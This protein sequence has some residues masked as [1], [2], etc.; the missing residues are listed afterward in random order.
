MEKPIRKITIRVAVFFTC[1]PYRGDFHSSL[2]GS[3]S[4]FKPFAS[5]TYKGYRMVL[6]SICE[7]ASIAFY[8]V[9]TSS[10]HICVVGSERCTNY[11]WQEVVLCKFYTNKNP[12]NFSRYFHYFFIVILKRNKISF[13]PPLQYLERIHLLLS[14]KPQY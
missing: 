10:Y 2:T 8:F 11:N 12:F 9:S 4:L 5:Y 7:Y 14:K 6:A 3:I 1:Q 13:V